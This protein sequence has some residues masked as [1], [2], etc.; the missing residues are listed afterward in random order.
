MDDEA[1]DTGAATT[2]HPEEGGGQ[3]S[4]ESAIAAPGWRTCFASLSLR[5]N[6]SNNR[7]LGLMTWDMAAFASCSLLF[8]AILLALALQ[9]VSALAAEGVAAEG[10]AALSGGSDGLGA[11]ATRQAVGVV[12]V[13]LSGDFWASWRVE[14]SFFLCRLVYALSALPYLVFHLPGIRTLLSHTFATGYTERGECVPHDSYGLSALAKW[15]EHALGTRELRDALNADEVE[16]LE[17]L[18]ADAKLTLAGGGGEAHAAVAKGALDRKLKALEAEL[19]KAFPPSHP[20]FAQIFPERLICLEY[21]RSL[22]EARV[23]RRRAA[24]ATQPRGARQTFATWD[25]H[26]SAKYGVAW[27]KDGSECSLC[28]GTFTFF[29]RRHHC[30]TCGRLCCNTCSRAKRVP[31]QGA[32]VAKRACDRCVLADD[33]AASGEERP[34]PSASAEQAV[35]DN[36]SGDEKGGLAHLATDVSSAAGALKDGFSTFAQDSGV[37]G[38]AP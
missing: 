4:Q 35:A 38:A 1:T 2:C 13:L 22:A 26:Q 23:A 32:D 24:L 25:E 11:E 10:G 8:A 17:R 33:K 15:L 3:G 6:Y 36:S 34:P 28:G 30:R 29:K 9:D 19:G 37:A 5:H 18:C 21:E 27:Q 12:D 14:I 20:A 31:P 16:R 7:I